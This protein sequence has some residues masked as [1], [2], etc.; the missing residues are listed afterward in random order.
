MLGIVVILALILANSPWKDYYTNILSYHFGFIIGNA[1][2]LNY[3]LYHWINDGLMSIFF[4]TVGLELK[5]E[6]V[7]GELSSFR[8]AL[9]PLGCALGGMIGPAAIY[10]LLNPSGPES[11]RW[12]IPMATDIAFAVGILYLI[13]NKVPNAFKIT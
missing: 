12:G 7:A 5:Q 8:K 6:F 13:G 4:L 2:F 11:V 3:S 10:H 9:L 1:H